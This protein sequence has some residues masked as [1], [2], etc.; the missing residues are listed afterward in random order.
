MFFSSFES[1]FF[2]KERLVT[3]RYNVTNVWLWYRIKLILKVSYIYNHKCNAEVLIGRASSV[4]EHSI[5]L[6][7]Q[8]EAQL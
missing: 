6:I 1:I 8:K 7:K 4:Q 2:P 5:I 3:H